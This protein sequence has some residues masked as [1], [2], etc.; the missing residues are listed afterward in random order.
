MY[1]DDST[2]IITGNNSNELEKNCKITLAK[3]HN[4]LKSNKLYLN[5]KKTVFMCFNKDVELNLFYENTPLN[6][7]NEFKILGLVLDTKFLFKKQSSN[8][9]NKINIANSSL[10][11]NINLK[12]LPLKIRNI[13][14]NAL[15]CSHINYFDIFLTCLNKTT[16]DYISHKFKT[17]NKKYFFPNEFQIDV[18]EI[19]Q[20]NIFKFVMTI[21][22]NKHPPPIFNSLVKY[23]SNRKENYFLLYKKP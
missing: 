15:I 6:Q 23:L 12:Q 19:K 11:K 5:A 20:K 9:I 7:V 13:I 8:I 2:C 18:N 1:A 21:L 16:Y 22:R 3:I 17:V 14:F 4:Y 10:I